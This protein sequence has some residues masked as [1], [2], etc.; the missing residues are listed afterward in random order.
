MECEA[1][2][3]KTTTT[4]NIEI[5]VPEESKVIGEF[6]SNLGALSAQLKDID[7]SLEKHETIQKE[8]RFRTAQETKLSMFADSK[9]GSILTKNT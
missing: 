3:A 6:K 4:G 5:N 7:I 9:T 2:Y 1:L 8:L